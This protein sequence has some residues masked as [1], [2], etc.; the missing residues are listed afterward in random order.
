MRQLNAVPNI[1]AGDS[2]YPPGRIRDDNSPTEVGTPVTEVLYGDLLQAIHKLIRMAGITYNDVPEN[3]TNGFQLIEALRYLVRNV[4]ASLTE[5]G[6]A[7]L[8][9]DAEVQAGIDSNKVITPSGL[10]SRTATEIRWGLAAICT[11]A[12]ALGLTINN[13]IVSPAKLGVVT[14]GLITKVIEIG[15]WNMDS[16]VNKSV[17]HG[18][19]LSKIL[20]VDVIIRNDDDSTR[21][22]FTFDHN[23][24]GVEG[25]IYITST[26][27]QMNRLDSGYFDNS[28]FN[29]TSYNRGWI[30]IK[31]L[32]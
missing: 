26:N 9:N 29:S 11:E 20:K 13:K 28:S 16:F 22:D 4:S 18:L 17:A 3:E 21:V 2:T 24:D 27:I 19:D 32:P 1:D 12:D 8:A 10:A 5:K 31:H 7:E 14:G 25:N 23:F 30:I 15:D 6:V